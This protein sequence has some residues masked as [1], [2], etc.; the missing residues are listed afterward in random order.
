M[1]AVNP[2]VA[3]AAARAE[4]QVLTEAKRALHLNG[5]AA[6]PQDQAILDAAQIKG[7]QPGSTRLNVEEYDTDAL[8]HLALAS[9]I[10]AALGTAPE[11]R[12]IQQYVS[13]LRSE[14]C[15]APEHFDELTVTELKEEPFCFKRLHLQRLAQSREVN[16]G[17]PG[18]H[19]DRSS[20]RGKCSLCG[21]D[22]YDTQ[23]RAKDPSTGF[24]QH[25]GC[26]VSLVAAPPLPTTAPN[27]NEN[28]PK[29]APAV[30]GSAKPHH[31]SPA[32][33]LSARPVLPVAPKTRP[34]LPDGKH[35]FLSYQWDVQENVKD[36]KRLL[37]ER[38]IKCWIDID[39]GMK[40]D[41]YDSMA[42]GVQGAACVICFMTQ[43]Y[44]DSQNCKLE[45][46]FAQQSG[47]PIIPVMMQANFTAK[48]WLGILTSGSIWTPMYESASVGDG[49]NK[50]I[51]QARYLIPRMRGDDSASDT[52]SE[53]SDQGADGSSFDVGA[54]GDDIFTLDERRE[55]LERLR[56]ETAPRAESNKGSAGTGELG[57]ALCPLPA[58]VPILPRGLYVTAEME[59]VLD[60][61]LSDNA[62]QIGF[63]GMG[64]IGKT[65]VSC[66]V[67]RNK[68]VRVKFGTVAWITLGQTPVLESCIDLLHQQLTGSALP[69]GVSNDQ[70]HEFLQKAFLGRSVLLILDDCWDADVAKHFTWVDH[71]TNSKVLISS[72]I[73]DVLEGGEIMDVNMPSQ[74]D[75]AKMLLN[76]AGMDVNALH[77]REE[78]VRVAE[79]CKRLP[80]TIG[81]AGKLIRQLA[82]G[83]SMSGASDWAEVVAL[84]EDEM[85]DPDGSLSI[86]ESVIR[87]SLKAIPEKIKGKVTQL[88]YGFAL[89][90]EDTLVPLPVLGMVFDACG[91]STKP[92]GNAAKPMPQ[93]QVRRY[94]KA[95]IDRSLVL[96]T[97]DR[98]QLH[99]V[100]LDYAKKQLQ[101]GAY[102]AAQRA[103]VEALRKSNRSPATVTGKY[104]QR[105]VR[106]HICESRDAAW[107]T[108]DQ[109]IDWLED[110][111]CG[112]QDVIAASAASILPAEALAKEAELAGEWWHAAL[113][114]NAL[115]LAL[116]LK[117]EH[118]AANPFFKLAVSASSKAIATPSSNGEAAG[119]L[120]QFDLDSFE[121]HGINYLF[122][123]WNPADLAAYGPRMQEVVATKAG[124]SKPLMCYAAE[125][126]LNWLPAI[127]SGN[128]QTSANGFWRLSKMIV[129]MCN[130]S[131][132]VFALSTE[133][134]REQGKAL[135][136]WTMRCAAEPMFKSPDFSWDLFEPN[137]DAIVE[138]QNA[139]NY[140][141]HHGLSVEI[142]SHDPQCVAGAPWLLTMQYGRVRDA[143]QMLDEN[144]AFATKLAEFSASAGYA[145][146][147]FFIAAFLPPLQ[148]IMG[149]P[150]HMQ[151]TLAILGI[152]FGNVEERLVAVTKSAQGSLVTTM[153]RKEPG[154]GWFSTPRVVWQIKALCI[155]DLVVPEAEAIA[156]LESLPDNETFCA[157]SMTMPQYDHGSVF[158]AYQTCWLA[159]AH[160]KVGLY[161]GALRFAD[162][163][164]ETDILKGGTP[165]RIWPQVVALACKG[166]V[167]AKLNRHDEALVAF[168]AAVAISHESYSMMAAFAYRELANYAGGGEAAVQAGK[169][170]EAK[171]KTF[172]GRM[173]RE[174]F[175]R[176][177]IAPN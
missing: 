71:S 146:T 63:C 31:A 148:H 106:H 168:Q 124:R 131:T 145:L 87:A 36:I 57:L 40:S 164:M 159:L 158:G 135:L 137:G 118:N 133:E 8:S 89:A 51:A 132:D 79:L 5:E 83:S 55:E 6:R 17:T 113:R 85:N 2:A 64:G 75:A 43:A 162:L 100:M 155:L 39:G 4:L 140:A 119:G 110:H 169:E 21:L 171:L 115:A 45:L 88:F 104:I 27:D 147:F 177:T 81:V 41:I 77:R 86:E 173:T 105:C 42:E 24:Y 65:T 103:L 108:G 56:E 174:E 99:D 16:T 150:K 127:M 48:G 15:D 19:P 69:E 12:D 23:P 98:P 107:E 92:G 70:K 50:L 130:E 80:L 94:L 136:T 78:V 74:S 129:D 14:G 139:Y 62:T 9:H 32:L 47:I 84:L 172:E 18:P 58:M 152:S 161:T 122:K 1:A 176:L 134:D 37:N 101:G 141:E 33:T 67:T 91:G 121:L 144:L 3:A 30:A 68:G 138:Y 142:V 72:R 82:Q 60:A 165:S 66:W 54:W 109:A 153:E 35:A 38:N 61:V 46:K 160:E 96:G 156:W 102:K 11:S 93:L 95:L 25:E 22:V 154:G 28:D 76:T 97:V 157:H 126:S 123:S 112:V 49:I 167:L 13:A 163:Q 53:S 117:N 120:K 111:I 26:R 7:S 20:I 151:S 52:A 170:L 143:L 34:L 90:P 73:R 125:L 116:V 166:R 149:S 128:E 29:A 44:Q 114:W 59:R 175:D 10:S